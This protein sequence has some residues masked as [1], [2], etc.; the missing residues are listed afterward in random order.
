DAL[1]SRDR[2]RGFGGAARGVGA[3]DACLRPMKPHRLSIGTMVVALLRIP[4]WILKQGVRW[5]ESAM[6][7]PQP[8]AQP[9]GPE[10]QPQ[11]DEKKPVAKAPK[12]S[13]K[14][15]HDGH[16]TPYQRAAGPGPKDKAQGAI[17]REARRR[18]NRRK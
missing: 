6:K 3:P 16:G 13:A 15:E 2:R 10:A 18:L 8:A 9:R 12:A 4:V 7:S 1:A 17:G 11:N 5:A 14:V